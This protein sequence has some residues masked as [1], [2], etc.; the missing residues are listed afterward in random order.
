MYGGYK[1]ARP[2]RAIVKRRD[3]IEFLEQVL[4]TIDD[5][6][7]GFSKAFIERLKAESPRRPDVIR[8]FIQ[9]AAGE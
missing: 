4:E 3:A 8:D 5:L 7:D 1:V 9:E 6:P 2:E